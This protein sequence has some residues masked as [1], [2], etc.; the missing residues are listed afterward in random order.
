MLLIVIPALGL[1]L[2]LAIGRWWA[3]FA[4]VA[5]GAWIW[6]TTHVEVSHWVLAL[7]YGGIAAIGIAIGVLI[8]K[9]ARKQT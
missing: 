4:A 7:G 1:I 3:L 5:F 8:R 9:R 2:G 6:E